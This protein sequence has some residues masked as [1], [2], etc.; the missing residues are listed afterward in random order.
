ME[1]Y[2]TDRRSKEKIF[3]SKAKDLCS[4]FF[5]G[6]INKIIAELAKLKIDGYEEIDYSYDGDSREYYAI[7][8]VLESDNEYIIRLDLIEQQEDISKEF[9][10]KEYEKLKKEF[11]GD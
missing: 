9:R 5:T 4:L 3:T 1:K 6:D 10:R 7:K 11:E 8:Y 2:N